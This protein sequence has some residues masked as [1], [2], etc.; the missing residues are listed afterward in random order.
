[1]TKADLTTHKIAQ[2]GIVAAIYF[3][4]CIALS[5]ISYGEIQ[6]RVAELLVLLCFWRPDFIIGVTIGCF[7]ANMQFDP[8]ALGYA[9]WHERYLGSL[10]FGFLCLTPDGGGLASIRSCR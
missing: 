8:W 6:F 5:F 4:L 7:L 2:N 3:V 9:D 10:P 1:M